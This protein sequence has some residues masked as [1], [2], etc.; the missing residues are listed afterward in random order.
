MTNKP[1][2]APIDCETIRIAAMAVAD[3]ETPLESPQEIADHVEECSACREALAGETSDKLFPDTTRRAA[4]AVDVWPALSAKLAADDGPGSIGSQQNAMPH[5]RDNRRRLRK[6]KIWVLSSSL[7]LTAMAVGAS[8][9]LLSDGRTDKDGGRNAADVSATPAPYQV[10]YDPPAEVDPDEFRNRFG[11]YFEPEF[12]RHQAERLDP[13]MDVDT[14]RPVHI[15]VPDGRLGTLFIDNGGSVVL[16]AKYPTVSKFSEGLAVVGT[17]VD[18]KKGHTISRYGYIDR[19]TKLVIPGAFNYA[20]LFS[21]GLAVIGKDGGFG[22]INRRGEIVISPRYRFASKF[23]DGLAYVWAAQ[24]GPNSDQW[25]DATGKVVF[26][27]NQ[28]D[29]GRFS[30]G[31]LYVNLPGTEGVDSGRARGYVDRNFK[32]VFRLGEDSSGY[33]P[34]RCEEFHEGMAAIEIGQSNQWSFISRD[35]TLA[36]PGPYFQVQPFSEGLAAVVHGRGAPA[37]W[38]Y[39]N[40]SGKTIIQPRFIEARPFTEGLACVLVPTDD[41]SSEAEQTAANGDALPSPRGRFAY[42][43]KEGHV[44]IKPRF[45]QAYSFEDGLARVSENPWHVGYID[46]TG[47]YVWQMTQPR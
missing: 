39:I 4:H 41:D 36:I 3:G 15:R 1:N 34:G 32:F 25:I 21:E 14:L 40:K 10:P 29:A 23:Q 43:D 24:D 22:Y 44:V 2:H 19:T 12:Q 33:W 38:G 37:R 31:L 13:E 18:A 5:K 7:V 30:E 35:G 20:E 11:R 47:A 26:E 8:W 42:I 46:K 6:S 27:I 16:A 28:Y 9:Y 17:Q 45:Y